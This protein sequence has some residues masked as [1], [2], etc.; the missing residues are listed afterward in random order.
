[1]YVR[2]CLVERLIDRALKRLSDT[3]SAGFGAGRSPTEIRASELLERDLLGSLFFWASV[4]Q[5]RHRFRDALVSFYD[6]LADYRR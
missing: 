2:H 4:F 5:I 6:G 1:M 3:T